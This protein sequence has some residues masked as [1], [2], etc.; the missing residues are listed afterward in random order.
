MIS[1]K[2]DGRQFAIY[3]SPENTFHAT[4]G[5]CTHEQEELADGLVMGDIVECPKY[6]GRSTTR[7]ARRP[8]CPLGREPLDGSGQDG[9]RTGVHQTRL[10]RIGHFEHV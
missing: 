2:Y 3:R 9:R 5:I 10:I 4:D 6:N 1:V 8:A 7:P